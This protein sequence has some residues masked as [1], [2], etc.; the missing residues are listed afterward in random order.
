MVVVAVVVMVLVAVVVMVLVAMVVMVLVA[1][2]V[3]VVVAVVVVIVVAFVT[4]A[5]EHVHGDIVW[6]REAVV[7]PGFDV[8]RDHA[9]FDVRFVVMVVV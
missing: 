1:M 5:H 2:V 6:Q 7:A 8:E 3:V 9:V 4:F